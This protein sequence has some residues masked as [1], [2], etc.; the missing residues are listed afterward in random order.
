MKVAG[1]AI[2][3]QAYPPLR[4]GQMSHL[5]LFFVNYTFMSHSLHLR[6][7]PADS[8]T[9]QVPQSFRKVLMQSRHRGQASDGHLNHF[10][11]QC[12]YIDAWLKFGDKLTCH[13]DHFLA[14][15]KLSWILVRGDAHF[16]SRLAA[17]LRHNVMTIW[18]FPAHIWLCPA[19]LICCIT[20]SQTGRRSPD[21]WSISVGSHQTNGN[22][23]HCLADVFLWLALR[24]CMSRVWMIN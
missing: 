3:S 9:K 1:F 12:V 18:W 16:T 7:A 23:R 19:A 4:R 17:I 6:V 2:F 10:Q 21:S 24:E 11:R 15:C 13:E 14:E 20:V 5:P 22:K 8:C